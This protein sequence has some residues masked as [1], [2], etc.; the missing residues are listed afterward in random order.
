MADNFNL[1]ILIK[2]IKDLRNMELARQLREALRTQDLNGMDT[3]L[4]SELVEELENDLEEHISRLER[5]CAVL[6]AEERL[7]P[8]SMNHARQQE[9]AWQSKCDLDEVQGVCEAFARARELLGTMGS[10]ERQNLDLRVLLSNL[11]GVMGLE[12]VKET[13][14]GL[15]FTPEFLQK[16]MQKG[17][18]GPKPARKQPSKELDDFEALFDLDKPVQ[19][20]NRLPKDF[21]TR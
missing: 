18:T 16:L 5:I 3:G 1:D 8:E 4:I 13:P 7:R 20:K 10:S 6:T 19:P 12:A 17:L 9:V 14:Q 2:S 21:R 11:G 15:Q